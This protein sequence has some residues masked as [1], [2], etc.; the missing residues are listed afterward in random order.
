LNNDWVLPKDYGNLAHGYCSTSYS[1]QGKTV[2][3]VFIAQSAES[4]LAASREQFYVSVSRGREK[5]TI[6]TDG[7][8]M[9]REAIRGSGARLS[10]TELASSKK[11]TKNNQE[12]IQSRVFGKTGWR[13]ILAC[14]P[15]YEKG[16]ILNKYEAADYAQKDYHNLQWEY[17]REKMTQTHPYRPTIFRTPMAWKI[18][19]E[20]FYVGYPAKEWGSNCLPYSY[21]TAFR[22]V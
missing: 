12:K 15:E 4:G 17:Q 16:A 20:R 1:A 9:L 18:S 13:L 2:D 8:S 6:Y 21:F 19:P 7:K 14:S 10:A 22:F 5:V 11:T 3:Q